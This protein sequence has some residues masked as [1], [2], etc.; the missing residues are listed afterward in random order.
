MALANNKMNS[1]ERLLITVYSIHK[2]TKITTITVKPLK[3]NG[4][5]KFRDTIRYKAELEAT[6][7]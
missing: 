6:C 1:T 2:W 7:K 4:Q 5:Y 3:S